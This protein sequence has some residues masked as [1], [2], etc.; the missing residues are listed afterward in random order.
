MLRLGCSWMG[1]KRLKSPFC[2]VGASSCDIVSDQLFH[3]MRELGIARADTGR[4]LLG[5]NTRHL[6][7]TLN[8]ESKPRSANI[9]V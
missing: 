1:Y 7:A 6:S 2:P 9:Q 3:C 8:N 4:Q 5:Q